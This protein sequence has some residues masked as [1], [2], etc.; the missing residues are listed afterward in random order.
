MEEAPHSLREAP[1]LQMFENV[2]CDATKGSNVTDTIMSENG[3]KK[4][5]PFDFTI[6]TS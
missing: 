4:N 1:V 2:V 5:R 3:H 6:T